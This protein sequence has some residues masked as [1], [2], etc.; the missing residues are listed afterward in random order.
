MLMTY[1]AIVRRSS[2]ALQGTN[3]HPTVWLAS[4]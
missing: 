4:L 2:S 3:W 1:C